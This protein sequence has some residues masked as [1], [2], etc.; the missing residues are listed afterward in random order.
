[1]G[2]IRRIQSLKK[3]SYFL[4]DVGQSLDKYIGSYDNILLLGDY[5]SV[6]EEEIMIEFCDT[7][8]LVN[9]IKEPTC[10]KSVLKPTCTN[11][12]LPLNDG[13]RH[14]FI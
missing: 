10:Y 11:V 5:N 2:L 13:N 6:I 8:N 1:M 4:N 7:Y 12:I 14:Y 3:V 9:L